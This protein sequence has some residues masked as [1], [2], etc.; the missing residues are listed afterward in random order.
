[1]FYSADP[2]V[3][4]P[5]ATSVATLRSPSSAQQWDGNHTDQVADQLGGYRA[6][7]NQFMVTLRKYWLVALGVLG[8][9]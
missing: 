3:G 4:R 9:G 2:D 5:V 7:P 8:S 6:L 1:M